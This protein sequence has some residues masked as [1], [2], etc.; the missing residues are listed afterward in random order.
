MLHGSNLGVDFTDIVYDYH[1]E[2]E[3]KV[4]E[5]IYTKYWDPV[6]ALLITLETEFFLSVCMCNVVTYFC[7]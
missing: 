3:E 6:S 2:E 4:E 5:R 7:R 1:S